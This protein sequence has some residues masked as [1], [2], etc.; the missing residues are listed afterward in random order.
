MII[1]EPFF[2]FRLFVLEL[3]AGTGEWDRQTDRQAGCN[4]ERGL[5]EGGPHNYST[6]SVL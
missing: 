3:E 6:F 5:L 4:A 2:A 1:L